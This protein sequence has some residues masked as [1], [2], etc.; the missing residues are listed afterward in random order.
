MIVLENF[1]RQQNTFIVR[2]FF[3]LTT[4]TVIAYTE[5]LERLDFVV[6]DEILHLIQRMIRISLL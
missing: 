6:Y 5:I 3:L 1:R 2:I 4:I